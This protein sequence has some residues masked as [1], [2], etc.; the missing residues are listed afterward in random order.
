MHRINLD[1][2]DRLDRV[3]DLRLGGASIDTERQQLTPVLRLFFGH[4][5]FLSDD[6]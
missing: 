6:R 1:L 2:E 5:R 3:F 4:Q